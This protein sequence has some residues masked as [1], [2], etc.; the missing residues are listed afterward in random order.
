[1]FSFFPPLL[2]T[3]P[4]THTHTHTHTVTELSERV[5]EE[6]ED[7]PSDSWLGAI[8]RG[9]METYVQSILLIRSLPPQAA[10]QL[11][12]DIGR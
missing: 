11:A 4:P 2:P 8:A 7:H 5:E 10:L 6:Q 1:V 12:T 9:T 3:H